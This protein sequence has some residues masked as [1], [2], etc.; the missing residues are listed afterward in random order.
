M[1]RTDEQELWTAWR[2]LAGGVAETEG[3][4]T[5]PIAAGL[6]VDVRAGRQFP[7]NREALLFGFRPDRLPMA[8]RLPQGRGFSVA[9]VDLEQADHTASWIAMSRLAM[10]SE[11]L[12]ATMACDVLS[13]MSTLGTASEDRLLQTFLA[14]I[15]AWQQ[16]MERGI[17]TLL[18]LEEEMGLFGELLILQDLLAA[19]LA[20]STVVD[21]WRGPLRSVRDLEVGRGGIEVKTTLS[22]TDFPAQISSLDQL[23]SGPDHPLVI[24]AIRLQVDSSGLT[25]PELAEALEGRLLPDNLAVQRFR[26]LMLRSGFLEAQAKSYERKFVRTQTRLLPVTDSFPRLVRANVPPGILSASYEIDLDR[27]ATPLLD[28]RAV[29]DLFGA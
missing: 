1:P 21:C 10:G 11:D 6:P 18:T 9:L 4:R 2:A 26:T 24:G 23:F 19:G 17:P 14:R 16:F 5:I 22:G 29:L 13:A 25:L 15:A 20:P 27:V 8:S 28:L 3:W 12:F 7:G